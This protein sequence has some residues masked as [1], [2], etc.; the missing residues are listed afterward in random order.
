MYV[1]K[2]LLIDDKT[3]YNAI[4]KDADKPYIVENKGGVIRISV[5]LSDKDKSVQF[6]KLVT[7]AVKLK[8]VDLLLPIAKMDVEEYEKLKE[9]WHKNLSNVLQNALNDRYPAY[10]SALQ[11]VKGEQEIIIIS[12]PIIVES[13]APSNNSK[14]ILFVAFFAALFFAIFLAF[15]LEAIENIRKDPEAMAKIR[16]ALKKDSQ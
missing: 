14:T 2:S 8:L 12:N 1:V 7:D 15:V 6:L 10:L 16:S 4:I 11:L 5:R 9:I 13:P 3:P